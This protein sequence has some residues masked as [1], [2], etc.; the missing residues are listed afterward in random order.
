M[1]YMHICS[2][3]KQQEGIHTIPTPLLSITPT[4]LCVTYSAP[5][6]VVAAEE[7]SKS[8]YLR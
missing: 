4:S 2:F 8:P 7:S 3:V 5:F 6:G 1:Y